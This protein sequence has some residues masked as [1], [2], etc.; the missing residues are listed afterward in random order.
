[1]SR[2]R[3]AAIRAG[4]EDPYAAQASRARRN[5]A[6]GDLPARVLECGELAGS[7]LTQSHK[8]LDTRESADANQAESR[9]AQLAASKPF[10]DAQKHRLVERS[11]SHQMTTSS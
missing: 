10:E 11:C 8:P 4:S 7:Q 3:S 5:W 9:A 2:S 1:M 6:A